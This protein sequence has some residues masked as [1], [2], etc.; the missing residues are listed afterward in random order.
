MELKKRCVNFSDWILQLDFIDDVGFF[1][2]NRPA[3]CSSTS[4]NPT[5]LRVNIFSCSE[6]SKKQLSFWKR[7][8]NSGTFFVKSAKNVSR[9]ICATYFWERKTT[10][11][12]KIKSF[13][14]C[15]IIWTDDESWCSVSLGR[16]YKNEGKKFLSKK[17][18]F[19]KLILRAVCSFFRLFFL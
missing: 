1:C 3:L 14:F 5:R 11:F 2:R 9:K 19:P 6:P 15:S 7:S 18:N 8:T 13:F 12:G 10:L 16:S 4:L 17:L